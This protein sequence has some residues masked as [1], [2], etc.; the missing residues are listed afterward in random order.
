MGEGVRP[1]ESKAAGASRKLE[2]PGMGMGTEDV[3]PPLEMMWPSSA[4]IVVGES[5]LKLNTVGT[6]LL[7]ALSSKATVD[8]S[9][10]L[11]S[12]RGLLFVFPAKKRRRRSE[13]PGDVLAAAVLVGSTEVSGV[14]GSSLKMSLVKPSRDC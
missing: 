1:S 9:M 5:R 4:S 11:S 2:Q 10:L 6:I 12:W 8:V 3:S 13:I 14:E 7:L